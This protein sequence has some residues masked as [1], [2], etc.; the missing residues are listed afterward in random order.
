M[1][2][3]SGDA[4]REGEE[5]DKEREGREGIKD[6]RGNRY[7]REG[8]EIDVKDGIEKKGEERGERGE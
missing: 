3:T 4:E 1:V 8:K 7:G 2:P 6:K 5:E